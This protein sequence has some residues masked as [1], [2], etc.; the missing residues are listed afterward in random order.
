M[1]VPRCGVAR[2]TTSL[3]PGT[4]FQKIQLLKLFAI[5]R[6]KLDFIEGL[7]W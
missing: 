4:G 6:L 3:I 7:F 2:K 5:L 1:R